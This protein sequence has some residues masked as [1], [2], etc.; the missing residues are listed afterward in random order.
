MDIIEE[1]KNQKDTIQIVEIVARL[2]SMYEL[3]NTALKKAYT[4]HEIELI[5]NVFKLSKYYRGTFGTG[6]PFYAVGEDMS[7]N[8]PIIL[9]QLRYNNELI[10]QCRKQDTILWACLNC[11]EERIDDFPNLKIYCKYCID[12]PNE[13]KPR[14][15]INRIPDL[16][17]WC[18]AGKGTTIK[19]CEELSPLLEQATLTTSDVNPLQ[20]FK[21]LK[22]IVMELQSGKM[23]TKHL[24]IDIHVVEEEI[25]NHLIEMV[26][27]SI[28][29]G[30]L[31]LL[32]YPY[33]LR[34]DWNYEAEGYNFIQDFLGSFSDL[35]LPSETQKKLCE[36]R[37]KLAKRYSVD[38]LY[39][40]LMET[41]TD[42]TKRRY[43]T[44]QLQE[45]FKEK[46]KKWKR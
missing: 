12:S 46:V 36:S 31:D 33:S 9:E 17:I 29:T 18:V 45:V 3:E 6:Y 19:I 44:V 7:H 5:K 20:T 40:I 1:L 30:N 16:D 13:L 25:L 34:K 42:S 43:E 21:D 11:L 41:A 24:P 26:P 27:G 10:E 28:G 38:E 15:V 4:Q 39:A 32:I 14:K 22:E 2:S 37:N 8:L 35:G 23:P